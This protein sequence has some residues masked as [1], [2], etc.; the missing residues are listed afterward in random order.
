MIRAMRQ[1]YGAA[2]GVSEAF[3][4]GLVGVIAVGAIGLVFWS[5]KR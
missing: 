4:Y 1:G 3:M 2:P 5:M